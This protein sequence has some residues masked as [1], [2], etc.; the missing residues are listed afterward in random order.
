M[1]YD[2]AKNDH[3]LA[4]G[5]FK[6]CVVPRPIGW[7]STVSREGIDNL[8]PYSQFQNL[9]FD[10][11]FVMFSANQAQRCVRKDSV[12][13]AEETGEFV[14]NMA[15]YDL[16]DAVN[17]SAATV[18]PEVDEFDLAGVTKAPSIKVKPCRV[19]ESP[20]QFECQYYQ[21]VRLPGRDGIGATDLVIGKVVLIHI[22]DEFILPDGRIDILRIRPL[23]RLGYYDYTTVDSAF[24]MWIPGASEQHMGG[25]EGDARRT[26]QK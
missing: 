4:R 19:A 8:A 11:P 18:P 6:S 15:T 7:I 9:G 1:Y 23:A 5:P 14:Y 26:R 24:E 12:I 13:N 16:R 3:G 22:K 20:I 2:P 17:R 10:P 25:L 21:T